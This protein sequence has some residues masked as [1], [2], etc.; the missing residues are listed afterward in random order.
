MFEENAL[1]RKLFMSF[2]TSEF[3]QMTEPIRMHDP[4]KPR[5]TSNQL[6]SLTNASYTRMNCII[7][8]ILPRTYKAQSSLLVYQI[9]RQHQNSTMRHVSLLWP[10]RIVANYPQKHP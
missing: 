5:P 2:G 4:A 6:H 8:E 3:H 9:A 10:L 7:V 1:L